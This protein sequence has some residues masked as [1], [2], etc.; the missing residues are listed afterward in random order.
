MYIHELC[1]SPL[2]PPEHWNKVI[3]FCLSNSINQYCSSSQWI[4]LCSLTLLNTPFLAF[5]LL[6][7]IDKSALLFLLYDHFS[8]LP[9]ESSS[10]SLSQWFHYVFHTGLEFTVVL[11]QILMCYLTGIFNDAKLSHHLFTIAIIQSLEHDLL[12]FLFHTFILDNPI[13][14]METS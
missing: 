14:Y 7:V 5:L 8:F 6:P 1:F 3:D 2:I 10:L 4:L 13:I 9:A 12:V 11:S